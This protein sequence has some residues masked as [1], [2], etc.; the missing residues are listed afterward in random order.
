M[1]ESGNTVAALHSIVARGS[2]LR[3]SAGAVWTLNRYPLL[4]TVRRTYMTSSMSRTALACRWIGWLCLASGI[5]HPCWSAP[6]GAPIPSIE[7]CANSSESIARD[8]HAFFP[9]ENLERLALRLSSTL[10][11]DRAT[12]DRLVR[13]VS[14]IRAR[15][16]ALKSITY[17]ASKDVRVLNVYFNASAFWRAR[18][19][20]YRDWNCLNGFLG[21]EVVFHPEFDY[22]ELTF[23]GLYNPDIIAE[24]Y[25]LLP[26]VKMTEFSGLIGDSSNIFV[27]RE[28]SAWHYV[29]DRA[30]GDCPSGCTEHELH[31]FALTPEGR[32]QTTATWTAQASEP[33]PD[34][35]TTYFRQYH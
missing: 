4:T 5:G 20:L 21:A 1:R 35:A 6:A 9:D 25:R 7:L 26:G 23:A 2:M 3:T 28:P 33:P 11:A 32:V 12:Y 8:S 10:Y 18:A 34:W 31:Y 19:H 16:P 29:F 24:A 22:A 27:S 30:G 15:A 14:L 13:D 17:I